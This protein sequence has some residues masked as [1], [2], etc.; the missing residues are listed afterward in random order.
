[1]N[2]KDIALSPSRKR[3]QRRQFFAK[4]GHALSPVV[5]DPQVGLCLP[6]SW[7]VRASAGFQVLQIITEPG[8]SKLEKRSEELIN[9]P[10]K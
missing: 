8:P 3:A 10:E 4:P 7:Q 1:M 5:S 2:P 6:H 9:W